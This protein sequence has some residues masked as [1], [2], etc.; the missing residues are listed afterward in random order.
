MWR[1]C[2]TPQNFLLAF[3]DELWKTQKKSEFCKNKKKIKKKKKI[4]EISS[5]YT[6]VPKTTIRYSPRDTEW[7]HSILSFSAIFCHLPPPP[8]H[9]SFLTLEK[10]KFWKKE[11][12]IWQCHH[13]KFVQQKTQSNDA[14]LLR[15]GVWQTFYHFVILGHFLLF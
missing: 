11:K 14:C 7:H 10:P 5:F 6:C 13:F 2:S 9:L 1:R 8:P 3:I 4:L 12:S 15:Y